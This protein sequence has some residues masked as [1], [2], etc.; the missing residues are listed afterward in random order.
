MGSVFG[1]PPRPQ[2]VR[3]ANSGSYLIAHNK[4]DCG[5][6]SP[7]AQGIGVFSQFAEWPMEHAVVMDNTVTMSPPP[8]VI[9]VNLS[10]GIGISGFTRDNVVANNR[11]RGRA[12]AA[13]AVDPFKGGIPRNNAFIHNRLDD[14]SASSADMFIGEGVTDTLLLGQEGTIEDH[15]VN[16]V[17]VPLR[18]GDD[19]VEEDGAGRKE[20]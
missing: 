1:F 17:I 6:A 15:G 13:L 3:V 11:I 4:I 9:F 14:F 7:E 12:R 19:S 8:G 5:W 10:A 2:A 20:R 16:T 18:S